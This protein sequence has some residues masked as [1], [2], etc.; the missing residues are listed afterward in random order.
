MLVFTTR[1]K[2]SLIKK[3]YPKKLISKRIANLVLLFSFLFMIVACEFEPPEKL[4]KNPYKK[5]F[6]KPGKHS[7]AK[8]AY[9][10]VAKVNINKISSTLLE[11]YINQLNKK[12][13]NK[14]LSN[15]QKLN[16][17]IEVLI[18][19]QKAKQRKLHKDLNIRELVRMNK[20]NILSNAYLKQLSDSIVIRDSEIE[21]V[22]LKS[23]KLKDNNEYKTRHIVV[24]TRALAKIILRQLSQGE[25]FKKLARSKSIGPSAS[26]GGALEWFRADKVDPKFSKAVKSLRLGEITRFPVKTKHGWHIILLENTRLVSPPKYEEVKSLIYTELKTKKINKKIK[27]LKSRSNITIN[28][29]D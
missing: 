14:K 9:Q 17:L 16:K 29:K 2:L 13:E 18:L 27:Q 22:Y 4:K 10:T 19:S 12:P 6:K 20:L 3:S 11:H 8:L 15:E 23:Y 24:K 1:F 26:F 28:S 5:L 7:K 21:S 25:N